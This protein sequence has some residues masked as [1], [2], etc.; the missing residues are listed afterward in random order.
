MPPEAPSLT[1]RTDPTYD[2][3]A[4]EWL[5]EMLSRL[6]RAVIDEAARRTDPVDKETMRQAALYMMVNR[7]VSSL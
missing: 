1:D 7:L 4:V 6:R 3:D 5:D 2:P